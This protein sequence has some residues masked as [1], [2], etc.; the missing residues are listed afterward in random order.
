M[1][2]LFASS[3]SLGQSRYGILAASLR[4]RILDGEWQ[5]GQ[6]IPSEASLAQ[7]YGVALGTLRQALSLLVQDGVLRRQ[8][9]KGTFVSRGL[10][11]ASMMRFFRFQ[12]EGGPT[13]TPESRIL[14]RRFRHPLVAEAKTFQIDSDG[15]VIQLERLRSIDGQPCLLETI[16]LPLPQFGALADSDTEDWEDLLYPMYQQRCAILVHHAQDE[17]KFAQLNAAQA[18]RLRLQAGHPCVLVERQAFDVAG[19]CVERRTTRGDAFS[20]TYTAHV[21]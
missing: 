6:M 21:R 19:R 1:N 5:P 4:Q 9:G 16:V 3:L 15:Q 18:S 17:L 11:N 8:H 10:D 14:N 13:V 2:S 7:S 12:S 20:F